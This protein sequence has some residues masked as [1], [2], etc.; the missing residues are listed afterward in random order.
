MVIDH[1]Q[2]WVSPGVRVPRRRGSDPNAT[3][4]ALVYVFGIVVALFALYLFGEHIGALIEWGSS[5][6]PWWR[7]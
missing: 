7:Q 1:R 3:V 6:E 5:P 2:R 4:A